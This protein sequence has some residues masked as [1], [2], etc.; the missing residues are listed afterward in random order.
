[1]PAKAPALTFPALTLDDWASIYGVY[2]I[3]TGGNSQ[4]NGDTDEKLEELIRPLVDKLN[5]TARYA[6]ENEWDTIAPPKD[7]YEWREAIDALMDND[8]LTDTEKI[9]RI[10]AWLDT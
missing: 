1:M 8:R 6:V 9:K 7:E 4:L 5:T 2:D 10:K 3:V